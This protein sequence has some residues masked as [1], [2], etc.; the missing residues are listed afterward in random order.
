M[1]RFS[2]TEAPV[3]LNEPI[4]HSTTITSALLNMKWPIS[5]VLRGFYKSES[6]LLCLFFVSMPTYVHTL[7]FVHVVFLLI[8]SFLVNLIQS[9]F[10][11][12]YSNPV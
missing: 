4:F 7:V 5:F 8:T 9:A 2:G 10:Q 12:E 6:R 1:S 3:V 11:K